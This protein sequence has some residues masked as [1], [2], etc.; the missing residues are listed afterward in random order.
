[1]EGAP[2]LSDSDGSQRKLESGMKRKF[3]IEEQERERKAENIIEQIESLMEQG[4]LSPTGHS[5]FSSA[6]QTVTSA[7]RYLS[8]TTRQ[9]LK[10]MR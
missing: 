9:S 10:S 7:A 6:W 1:M 4:Y 5:G 8:A 2:L 3:G